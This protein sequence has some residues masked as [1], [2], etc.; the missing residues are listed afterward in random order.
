MTKR[1]LACFVVLCAISLIAP[2]PVLAHEGH[3]HKVMGTVKS[4]QEKH[5]EVQDQ[6]GKTTAFMVTDQTKILRGKAAA[7]LTDIKVGD[8]VVVTA[9]MEKAAGGIS[10]PEHG[11]DHG[12]MMTAKE[13]RLAVA[14]AKTGTQ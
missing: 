1:L 8:R 5:L 14:T 6:A 10:T 4:L 12:G 13:I 2:R 9:V 7:T 11:S 3:E